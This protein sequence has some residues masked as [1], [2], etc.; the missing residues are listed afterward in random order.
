[1][2]N[3][4]ATGTTRRMHDARNDSAGKLIGIIASEL[5]FQ[6]SHYVILPFIVNIPFTLNFNGTCRVVCA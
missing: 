1:M 3:K 6:M 4:V 2:T 5:N